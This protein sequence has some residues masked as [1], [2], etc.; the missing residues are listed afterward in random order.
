VAAAKAVAV[1]GQLGD[2]DREAPAARIVVDTARGADVMAA[3]DDANL[4][5]AWEV[6]KPTPLRNTADRW[7]LAFA[8]GD[9]VD[10]MYRGPGDNLDAPGVR[11]GDLRLLIAELD[12]ELKAVLYRPVSDAKAPYLFD[13]FEGAGRANAVRMDEVRLAPEVKSALN[14]SQAGYIVEAAIPWTLLGGKPATDAEFRVDF[15]VLFGGAAAGRSVERRA[16][17][18]NRD[19]QITADIPSEA[20]LQPANWGAGGLK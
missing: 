5:V 12:G 20:A 18:E 4:Y 9:A 13:A 2:W 15:G 19:T 3:W 16:Y 8:G 10:L 14:T 6:R 1:D 11:Q 7:E 17:W